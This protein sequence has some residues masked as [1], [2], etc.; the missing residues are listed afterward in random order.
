MESPG[1]LGVREHGSL[2][3]SAPSQS[4][5]PGEDTEAQERGGACL[6]ANLL[7][8]PTHLGSLLAPLGWR[9]LKLLPSQALPPRSTARQTHGSRVQ[10]Q[11]SLEVPDCHA[12][13]SRKDGRGQKGPKCPPEGPESRMGTH[14][15]KLKEYIPPISHEKV[16]GVAPGKWAPIRKGSKAP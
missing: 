5:G 1:W 10:L 8:A 4:P 3:H 7:A 9:R 13:N 11:R 12:G 16:K 15:R 6:R 2:G 14:K